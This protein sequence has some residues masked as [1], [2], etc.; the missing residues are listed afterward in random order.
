MSVTTENQIR[1]T[2]LYLWGHR[3]CGGYVWR[4]DKAIGK[5]KRRN[6]CS[7]W[8][9]RG[10]IEGLEGGNQLVWGQSGHVGWIKEKSKKWW[11]EISDGLRVSKNVAIPSY[12]IL[13][14]QSGGLLF[15]SRAT[16]ITC[17]LQYRVEVPPQPLTHIKSFNRHVFLTPPLT[18]TSL[19][20]CSS[21]TL[22]PFFSYQHH[23]HHH[24]HISVHILKALCCCYCTFSLYISLLHLLE[25]T[26]LVPWESMRTWLQSASARARRRTRVLRNLFL[27]R[28]TTGP[29]RMRRYL[30]LKMVNYLREWLVM[31]EELITCRCS[32][33]CNKEG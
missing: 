12:Y 26:V 22:F 11:N 14:S 15:H 10:E 23:V 6:V 21:C 17:R 25:K 24:L 27:T 1:Q 8:H 29:R 4:M 28:N 32:H 9:E 3:S 33:C 31:H 20:S 2:Y 13:T 16:W 7:T 5:C 18:K 19:A 30:G